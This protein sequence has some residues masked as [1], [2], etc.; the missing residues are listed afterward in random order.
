MTEA[1]KVFNTRELIGEYIVV[2]PKIPNVKYSGVMLEYFER[3]NAVVLKDYVVHVKDEEGKWVVDEEGDI[4]IIKGD[5]WAE[6]R[7]PKFGKVRK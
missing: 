7:C 4:L 1:K 6:I 3:N 5:C 2:I